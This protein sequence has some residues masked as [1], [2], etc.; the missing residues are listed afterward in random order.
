MSY[1][2]P[3]D[4]FAGG[5]PRSHRRPEDWPPDDSRTATVPVPTPRPE[6]LD[7]P[8]IDETDPRGAVPAGYADVGAEVPPRMPRGWNEDRGPGEARPYTEMVVGRDDP[9]PSQWAPEREPVPDARAERRARAADL[10]YP[11]RLI[12]PELNRLRVVGARLAIAR[13][14]LLIVFLAVGILYLVLAV[15]GAFG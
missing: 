10:Q 14:V 5:Q 9:R 11:R 7:L 15:R 13:D 3:R 8:P 6:R 2:S 4:R 12:D 1:P